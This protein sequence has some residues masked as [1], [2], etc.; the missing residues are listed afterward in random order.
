MPPICAPYP[1]SHPFTW[2]PLAGQRHAIDRRDRNV[3]IGTPMRCLCGATHPRG[4]DG[5]S[6]WLWPTCEACWDEA[7]RIVGLRPAGATR[8][9]ARSR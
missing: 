6:E 5:D 9:S 2:F 1:E 4:A 3:P 7:C 8:R